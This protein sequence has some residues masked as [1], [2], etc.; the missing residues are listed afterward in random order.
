MHR[1]EPIP[2]EKFKKF[3]ERVL[4]EARGTRYGR[5]IYDRFDLSRPIQFQDEGMVPE[6]EILI[7]IRT[8]SLTVEKYL[9]LLDSIFPEDGPPDAPSP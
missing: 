3:I 7:A 9:Y 2:S 5:A 4:C 8:L 1:L 6:Q